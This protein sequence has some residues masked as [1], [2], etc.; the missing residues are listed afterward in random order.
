M[1]KKILINA[2]HSEEKRVAI[3]E[4]DTLV[5]FYVEVASKE[6]LK[7]NIYKGVIARIEPGLQA[8]FV[9]F[10]QKKQGFLQIREISPEHFQN[11]KEGKRPRVQDVLAKGQEIIVQVEKDE[12]DTKGASLTTY[13]SLPGRYIVMMPGQKRVGISRKIE[14]RDDRDRLKELFSSLKLPKDMG[15]ILRTACSDISGEELA[16]DLKYL[17]KLWNKIQA[18]SKKAPAPALI[19]KEQDM[20]VRTVRDYLTSDVAEVLVDDETAYRRIKEFLRKTIPWR[21]I[22]ITYYRGKEPIFSQHAIEEQI[23]RLNERTVSLP[24]HGYL[25]FDKTEA[26]TAIDVNSG[27]SRKEENVEATALKT[28]LEAVEEIARQLRLRDIGGLVVMDFIDM[29]SA[30]NRREVENSLKKALSSD[31]AHFDIT[32]IS[33]FGIVEMTR[34]RL[35]TSYVDSMSTKCLVCGGAGTLRS[36]EMVAVSA[37]RE[38]HSK[39]SAGNVKGLIC[40]LPV[41]SANYLIN[42][43]RAD[44]LAL[45]KAF[46]IAITVMGDTKLLPGQFALDVEAVKE[47]PKEPTKEVR[48]E[49][50]QHPRKE[51]RKEAQRNTPKEPPKETP[52]EAQEPQAVQQEVQADAQ[53]DKPRS[54]RKSRQRNR[55]RRERESAQQIPPTLPAPEAPPAGGQE[56]MAETPQESRT[57]MPSGIRDEA[58]AGAAPETVGEPQTEERRNGEPGQEREEKKEEKGQESPV[59]GQEEEHREDRGNREEKG[60]GEQGASAEAPRDAEQ[61]QEQH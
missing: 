20:A 39:L 30:K 41:E 11:K 28:N 57:D 17:T 36:D 26:L 29:E 52:K 45:E 24:S 7:G 31:K 34:E 3:V 59:S 35:R 58:A 10:G 16:N 21:K 55:K 42:S 6:Q 54:R 44:I 33:R 8:A 49:A 23:S 4:G 12:R 5:D 15:F 47:A 38:I 46:G 18:E 37:L 13:L 48:K 61:L 51:Q 1:E 27:R 14:D 19:Y 53:K 43:K 50:Q 60:E 9:D 56:V 40:R 25:V 32:G 2:L 22:N